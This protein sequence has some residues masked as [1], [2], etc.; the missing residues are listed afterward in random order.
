MQTVL[1]PDGKYVAEVSLD[2]FCGGAAVR[3]ST[4]VDVRSTRFRFF[5][6]QVAWYRGAA[7]VR[8][9]WL[10]SH[11]L[12][13]AVRLKADQAVK[14]KDT[15]WRDVEFAFDEQRVADDDPVFSTPIYEKTLGF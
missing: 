1:S 3:F 7:A 2:G 12:L 4:Y 9:K 11:K 8:M 6:D 13:L 10:S 14:A 5:G 15:A